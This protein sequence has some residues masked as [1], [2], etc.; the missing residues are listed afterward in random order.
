MMKALSDFEKKLSVEIMKELNREL[1]Y[2][3]I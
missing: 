1:R 3:R 2:W